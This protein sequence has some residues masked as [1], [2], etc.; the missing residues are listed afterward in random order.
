MKQLSLFAMAL[1]LV[2]SIASCKKDTT[3]G[4]VVFGDSKEMFV[5]SCQGSLFPE[6]YGHYSWGNLVDLNGDGQGD[7]Q[8]HWWDC[9]SEGQGHHVE[10]EHD[11]VIT[12]KCPNENVGLLGNIVNQEF[13]LCA[14]NANDNFDNNN[15]F[16]CT[17]AS[18]NAFPMDEVKYIGF[19]LT[20]NNQSR[21]GWMKVNLHHD[22]VELL[23]TAIQK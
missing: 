3:N 21:L 7:I 17:D 22:H 2:A 5:T 1:L 12:L 15:T 6:Q 13:S 9:A 10:P 14:N 4:K 16:K 19:K 8:F 11:I 23:E 18:L 20:E